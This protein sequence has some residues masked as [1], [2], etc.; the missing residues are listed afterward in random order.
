MDDPWLEFK[1]AERIGCTIMI[2][3]IPIGFVL[4]TAW[5]LILGKVPFVLLLGW[6]ATIYVGRAWYSG[7]LCPRCGR[8]F[9][10]GRIAGLPYHN[11]MSRKCLN[12][13]LRKYAE[14][15]PIA[16]PPF[17]EDGDGSRQ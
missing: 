13:G 12:C 10:R 15:D 11:N 9:Y 8:K 3:A 6:L 5:G 2:S 14:F 4:L 1:R 7:P 16:T 17:D